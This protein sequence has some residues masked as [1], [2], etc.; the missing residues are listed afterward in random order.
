MVSDLKAL[1]SEAE[2]LKDRLIE[3][4]VE[5][6]LKEA[7][8]LGDVRLLIKF[9][10]GADA[11]ASFAV[12]I[13][14]TLV[15]KDRGLAAIFFVLGKTVQVVVMVGDEA[16]KKG[17]HAGKI[18]AL[19]ADRAGGGLERDKVQETAGYLREVISGW[20]K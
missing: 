6:M 2:R 3:S 13:A 8:S 9:M 11:D 20:V 1:R 17:L 12:K 15:N 5:S 19:V 4:Q 7:E 18:V 10:E 14:N 16:Q